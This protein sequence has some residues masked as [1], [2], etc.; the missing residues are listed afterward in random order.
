M[1]TA[2]KNT[3]GSKKRMADNMQEILGWIDTM[4]ALEG[5]SMAGPKN[6]SVGQSIQSQYGGRDASAVRNQME[7]RGPSSGP[8]PNMMTYK[9]R[10]PVDNQ[11][12]HLTTARGTK[13]YFKPFLNDLAATGY[14]ID[15]LG[16]YNYR[17]ARGS[18]RLSEHAY[19]RAID[20]NPSSNPMGSQLI[21]DLPS[22]VARLAAL[23]NLI[24][25]GTWKSKKDSMHFSTTGY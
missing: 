10:D 24:W 12:F 14:D 11:L 8:I 23:H 7:G 2:A 18:N 9:W 1:A 21:T 17:N 16:G 5:T 25:G 15:S 19:G 22:N 4:D 6:S 20:I 3:A 13:K